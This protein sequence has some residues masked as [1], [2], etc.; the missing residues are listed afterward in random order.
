MLAVET[1]VVLGPL[2]L[3]EIP[4]LMELFLVEL[5]LATFTVVQVVRFSAEEAEEAAELE[6]VAPALLMEGGEFSVLAERARSEEV[7]VARTSREHSVHDGGREKTNVRRWAV[8]G[9]YA[10]QS[11]A[12]DLPR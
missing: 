6:E 7:P 8:G 9:I 2:V 3:A 4:F 11:R 12:S 10:A 5:F 1:L